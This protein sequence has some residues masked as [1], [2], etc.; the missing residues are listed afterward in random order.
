MGGLTWAAVGFLGA[1]LLF[2]LNSLFV[3]LLQRDLEEGIPWLAAWLVRRAVRNLPAKH[4]ERFEEE[5]LAELTAI[6]GVMV[7]KLRFAFAIL[8]RVR[9]TSRAMRGLPPWWEEILGRLTQI[10]AQTSHFSV[11]A[12]RKALGNRVQKGT[13][14]D[15]VEL[16]WRLLKI[17]IA[18]LFPSRTRSAL[19]A[20]VETDAEDAYQSKAAAT[21]VHPIRTPSFRDPS[22]ALRV[23]TLRARE[24]EILALLVNGHSN[25]RIAEECFLSLNTVRTYVQNILVKLGVHSKLEAVAFALEHRI[26]DSGQIDEQGPGEDDGSR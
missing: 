2:V 26:V 22:V 19:A 1:A 24:R 6:P 18:W 25:R 9:A 23:R 15:P 11:E 12:T 20:S 21:E 8:F 3:P 5:W 4:Q 16:L 13:E 14:Q 17:S 7:F 10:I